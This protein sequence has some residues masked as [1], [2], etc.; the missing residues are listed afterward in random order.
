ME[1]GSLDKWVFDCDES[2]M[3]NYEDKIRIIKDVAYA[4]LYLHEG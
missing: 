1:N 2:K 4:I 3:L